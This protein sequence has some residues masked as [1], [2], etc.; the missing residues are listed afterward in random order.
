MS[1]P[2]SAAQA[3]LA[4]LGVNGVTSAR[5]FTNAA[6]TRT[7]GIDVIAQYTI[8]LA[9]SS[10]NLTAGHNYNKTEIQR[11]A[12]NPPELTAGGLNLQR[13]GRVEQGRITVGAPRDKFQL[14]GVWS[15]G[16]WKFSANATR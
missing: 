11:I 4:S 12:P 15:V 6:D 14:G 16:D 9:N 3:L 10:L 1:S 13:I 5:N 8:P 2:I 7:R